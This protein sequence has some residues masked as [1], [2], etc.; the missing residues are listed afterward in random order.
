[1]ASRSSMI[2]SFGV[3]S[4]AYA[5]AGF[6]GVEGRHKGGPGFFT[7]LLQPAHSVKGGEEEMWSVYWRGSLVTED[8]FRR[9]VRAP[10]G[11]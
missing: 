2:G 1:M 3:G 8:G 4:A 11:F 6:L 7:R 9:C 10:A 5:T